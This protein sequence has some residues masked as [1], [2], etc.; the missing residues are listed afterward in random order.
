[1]VNNG[2]VERIH[3]IMDVRLSS[4]NPGLTPTKKMDS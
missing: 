4:P 2:S 1:V 3:L